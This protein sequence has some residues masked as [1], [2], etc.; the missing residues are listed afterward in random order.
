MRLA[1]EEEIASPLVLSSEWSD[2]YIFS[3][4]AGVDLAVLGTHQGA[5]AA[6]G[7]KS[8]HGVFRKNQS[9]R[10][11]GSLAKWSGTHQDRRTWSRKTASGSALDANGNTLTDTQGRSDTWDFENRL[12]Q[13]VN[14]GVGT[15][16][17]RYDPFG[18]RIQKSGPLGTTNFLYDG[19]NLL[20]EVDNSGSLLA[21]YTQSGLIDE[22][23]SEVRSST[24][25]Y[26]EADDLS[27]ITSFSNSSG[28]LANNY[29]YGSFGNLTASSGSIT[30]PFRFTGREFDSETGMYF[31]RSR[32]FDTNTGRFISE[33]PISFT[34]GL[35]FYAYVANNP[36]TR[37][38]PSGMDAY[39]WYKKSRRWGNRSN[40]LI[41]YYACLSHL[42]DTR[43]S[44][45][46][47]SNDAILNTSDATGSQ[48]DLDSQRLKCALN[49]DQNCKDA[50]QRCIKLGLTNP[51]PPPWW[52]SD[53][54]NLVSPGTPKPQ[55]P[56]P[57]PNPYP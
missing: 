28:V 50:L 34:G 47:M 18:R 39:D 21:H 14:P 17:F 4:A 31:Y 55:P 6:Q 12:T 46:Q 45:D 35:D 38:D 41:S 37:I 49:Q 13:V 40:C 24:T 22:T 9:L 1:A 8:H 15:A 32:Y 54:I 57:T 23:L 19:A 20:Q 7:K 48:G 25:S 10:G 51:F 30:N 53:I 42:S 56:K 27:S 2:E 44:L 3:F 33:D 43:Q 5:R 52:L 29:A 26:Y 11:C 16:N 36:L